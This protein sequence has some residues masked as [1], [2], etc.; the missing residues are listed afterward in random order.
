MSFVELDMICEEM[1]GGHAMFLY[2][3]LNLTIVISCTPQ[4]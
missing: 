2:L 3:K 4:T 1:L